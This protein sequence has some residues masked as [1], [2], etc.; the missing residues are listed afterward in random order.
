MNCLIVVD[1]WK[2]C[3]Q[4]DLFK[5]PW[6]ENETKLFGSFLN[7][8]LKLIRQTYNIDIIHH[9]SNRD[10]MEEI[11]TFDDLI[12]NSTEQIPLHYTTYYFCG[13]HLGRCINTKIKELKKTNVGIVLNLSMCFPADAFQ[14][15]VNKTKDV[16]N[17][18]YSYAK[19]F[20]K[21][22]IT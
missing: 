13:F 12:V 7:Q 18:F 5:F 4:E 21:C 19:G 6:L 3:E 22:H 11:E 1:A 10:I 8:Q 17:Y 9:S 20:E 14:M 2:T 15:A 16:D